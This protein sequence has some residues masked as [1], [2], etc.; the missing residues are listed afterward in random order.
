MVILATLA[1]LAGCSGDGPALPGWLFETTATTDT[2]TSL[3]E[4]TSAATSA[5]AECGNGVIEGEEEC[6]GDDWQGMTCQSFGFISGALACA[7]CIYDVSECES[8]LGMVLI[9]ASEFEMGSN[10]ELNEQPI[11]QVLVD[12]FWID[13][14]EVTVA[15]YAMCPTCSTPDIGPGCNWNVAGMDNHPVNC[16]AW[17]E[18]TTYC[19]WVA[20]GTR[21]LPTEAE[22]EMAA[23]GTDARR[24]PWGDLPVP[25]CTHIVMEDASMGGS[26]CGTGA[27]MPVGSKPMGASPYGAQDMAGNVWEWVADWYEA[28]YDAEATNNPTGPVMGSAHIVRGGSWVFDDPDDFR[29]SNRAFYEDPT[30]DG[31]NVGFRCAM[32]PALAPGSP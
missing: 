30:Y 25:S 32:S 23:R 29:T 3:G 10:D 1:G 6:D 28:P 5:N 2:G 18:A 20:G 9:P 16:V 21:R 31:F 22:W 17:D 8:P 4:T 11:R 26:G 15:D 14:W 12:A 7:N 13:S 24:Y 27:T 19:A